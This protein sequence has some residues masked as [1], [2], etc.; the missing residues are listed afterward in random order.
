MTLQDRIDADAF[1]GNG[2]LVSLWTPEPATIVR[3]DCRVYGD[4][5]PWYGPARIDTL[6]V[7]QCRVVLERLSIGGLWLRNAYLSTVRDV[8]C[9]EG[10]LWIGAEATD[11]RDTW[12]SAITLSALHVR[13]G[14]LRIRAANV[15]WHGGSV[16]RTTGDLEIGSG[17]DVGSIILTGVRFEHDVRKRLVLRGPSPV[18]LQG[19][20]LTCTDVEIA[21]DAHPD[22]TV[23]GC[24]RTLSDIIDRRPRKPWWRP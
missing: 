15:T 18:I 21:P 10:G 14:P 22:T 17:A 8:L 3:R 9:G 19:C 20:H 11:G 2:Y 13:G 4:G 24:S 1:N 12:P 23:V 6:E 7:G 5:S 16:E